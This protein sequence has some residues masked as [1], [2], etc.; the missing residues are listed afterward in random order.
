MFLVH[1]FL[2][3]SS[4]HIL[5]HLF[6][7]GFFPCFFSF[8]CSNYYFDQSKAIFILLTIEVSRELEGQYIHTIYGAEGGIMADLM[9]NTMVSFIIHV[10]LITRTARIGWDGYD[11]YEITT[12]THAHRSIIYDVY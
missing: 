7:N 10:L 5:F 3:Q 12:T 4:L 8:F 9:I 11:T 1:Y 2:L 6:R